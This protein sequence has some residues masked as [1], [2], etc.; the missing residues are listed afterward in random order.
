MRTT[1]LRLLPNTSIWLDTLPSRATITSAMPATTSQA[2]LRSGSCGETG[3][4]V[5]VGAEDDGD[6]SNQEGE[7]EAP[8]DDGS[9]E[10]RR[11]RDDDDR[12]DNWGR[13]HE[14]PSRGEA[15]DRLKSLSYT[16]PA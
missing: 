16:S 12:V 1:P 10:R 6:V 13:E 2:R 7:A 9:T 14:A 4:R 5:G 3:G 8:R 11:R 15:Q